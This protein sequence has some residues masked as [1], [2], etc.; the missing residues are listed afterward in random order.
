MQRPILCGIMLYSNF[1]K[2]TKDHDILELPSKDD[3]LLG[4]HAIVVCGF[5][6]ET[7]TFEI[8]QTLWAFHN[9]SSGTCEN[10]IILAGSSVFALDHAGYQIQ[11]EA[12]KSII[13][14]WAL[15]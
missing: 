7:K 5:D 3:E 12:A 13:S 6:E 14:C 4:G 15:D 8:P 9:A 10:A 11:E 1:F 2:L